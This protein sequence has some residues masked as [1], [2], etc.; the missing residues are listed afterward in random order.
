MGSSQ[1]CNASMLLE[2][3]KDVTNSRHH[4]VERMDLLARQVTASRVVGSM[5]IGWAIYNSST[6]N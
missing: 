5:S 4:K 2:S 1:I 3:F 6:Q